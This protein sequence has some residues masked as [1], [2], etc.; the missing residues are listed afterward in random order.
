MRVECSIGIKVRPFIR[1]QTREINELNRVYQ[2]G[3]VWDINYPQPA[4]SIWKKSLR[5]GS[6]LDVGCGSGTNALFLANSGFCVTGIDVSMVAIQL[7]RQRA[8][9]ASQ[10]IQ[11]QLMAASHIELIGRVFDS[12]VESAVY[13]M[14][15]VQE[16]KIYNRALSKVL[17]AGGRL[18]SISL[19]PHHERFDDRVWKMISQ[20]QGKYDL[21]GARSE[22]A[23]V[24]IY[25]KRDLPTLH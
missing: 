5:S 19:R 24:S 18:L 23:W 8:Q 12:V 9:L 2:E 15:K 25:E 21:T 22:R 3:A 20:K 4:V 6:L 17:R 10:D 7:A 14:L 16:R 13:H 1:D 11:F